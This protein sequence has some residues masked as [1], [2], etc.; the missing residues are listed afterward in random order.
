MLEGYI[1]VNV[2]C[3]HWYNILSGIVDILGTTNLNNM[4]SIY[5]S[6]TSFDK[7]FIYHQCFR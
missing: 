1:T 4:V 5:C 2:K 6:F 3:L 7:L